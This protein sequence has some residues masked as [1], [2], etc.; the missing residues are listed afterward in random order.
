MYVFQPES[1]YNDYV[2]KIKNIALYMSAPFLKWQ[3]SITNKY[4]FSRCCN[5]N[6][7]LNRDLTYSE[8][9]PVIKAAESDCT[10]S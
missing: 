2:T 3:K 4:E 6:T 8:Y 9:Y 5:S 1:V 7:G 10:F